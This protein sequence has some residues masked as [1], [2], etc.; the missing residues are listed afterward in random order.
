[1]AH[2]Y[3]VSKGIFEL[4]EELESKVLIFFSN[5]YVDENDCN[6]NNIIERT[7][8]RFVIGEDN[9]LY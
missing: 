9:A 5:I 6:P 2:Y 3:F 4:R 7:I 8:P 1:M